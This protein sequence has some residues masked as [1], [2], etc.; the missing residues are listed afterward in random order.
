M[1][2]SVTLANGARYSLLPAG[3]SWGAKTN[4]D[5]YRVAMRGQHTK[6]WATGGIQEHISDV[7]ERNRVAN[8]KRYWKNKALKCT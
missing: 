7:A 2:F 5:V 4:P 8:R 3:T 1:T 6:I